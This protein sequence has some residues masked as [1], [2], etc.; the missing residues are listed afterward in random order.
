MAWARRADSSS[1]VWLNCSNPNSRIV[2]SIA[3]RGAALISIWRSKR[4]VQCAAA[5]EHRK[6]A[7]RTLLLIVQ[8]VVTPLNRSAQRLLACWRIARA[9]RE[10][11]QRRRLQSRQHRFRWE[12]FDARCGQLNGQREP[13]ETD[14][15]V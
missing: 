15:Y 14:A 12:Q 10:Q 6:P 7:K 9:T 13:T 2:S 1:A 5:D 3:K 11:V 4:R 8:Q